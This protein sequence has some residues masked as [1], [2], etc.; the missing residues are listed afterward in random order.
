MSSSLRRGT[1]SLAAIRT[2]AFVFP[3]S[4][5][6]TQSAEALLHRAGVTS[7]P[8]RQGSTVSDHDPLKRRQL[9]PPN[10][11]VLHL[12]RGSIPNKIDGAAERLPARMGQIR[13]TFGKMCL[14]LNLPTG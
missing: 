14:P 7:A 5:G 9:Q 6:K 11:S 12:D 3:S 1:A 2:P 13:E 8:C 4:A 10:A